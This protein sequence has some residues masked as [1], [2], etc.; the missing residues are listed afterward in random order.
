MRAGTIF[1]A[2]SSGRTRLWLR[3][4]PP[5]EDL[6]IVWSE[7]LTWSV[8]Q[9]HNLSSWDLRD[10]DEGR[11]WSE[12]IEYSGYLRLFT[13]NVQCTRWQRVCVYR[14]TSYTVLH[15][16]LTLCYTIIHFFTRWYTIVHYDTLLYTIIHYYTLVYTI[17]H[18]DFAI[19]WWEGGHRWI[20]REPSSWGKL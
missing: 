2:F 16:S 11:G 1:I 7:H 6:G 15:H 9:G 8:N 10:V 17:G 5:A 4:L 3:R 19:S 20:W 18:C 12:Y 13:I 14:N